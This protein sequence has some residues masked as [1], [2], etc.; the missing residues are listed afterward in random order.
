MFLAED[1]TGLSDE[2]EA[3]REGVE[4]IVC[5]ILRVGKMHFEF[6]I[7]TTLRK[8]RFSSRC[9]DCVENAIAVVSQTN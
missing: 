6:R 1:E 2:K 9:A 3:N 8:H 5:S 4:E 7:M